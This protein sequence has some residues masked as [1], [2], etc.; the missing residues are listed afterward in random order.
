MMAQMLP[1]QEMLHYEGEF[2][3]KEY[4]DAFTESSE[5]DDD[6]D[7]RKMFPEFFDIYGF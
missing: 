4:Y 1:R 6:D 3:G 2:D 5:S 7:L